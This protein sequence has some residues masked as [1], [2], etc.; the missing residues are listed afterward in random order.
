MIKIDFEKKLNP[1]VI[2]ISDYEGVDRKESDSIKPTP[3][4]IC[5]MDFKTKYYF[6]YGLDLEISDFAKNDDR[7]YNISLDCKCL[8]I[9]AKK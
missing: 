3:L 4:K 2:M 7:K 6:I 8:K 5:E 9:S 1:N